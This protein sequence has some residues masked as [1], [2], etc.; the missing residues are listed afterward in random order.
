MITLINVFTCAPERQPELMRLLQAMTEEVTRDLP[1]FLSASLH[2]SLDGKQ[3]A[4][5]AEWSSEADW[6]NM[7]RHPDIQARMGAIIAIA[8]FQP[9]LYERVSVHVPS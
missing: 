9:K 4:N 1:G 8:T 7:V 2:R 6:K 3:V 5:Y